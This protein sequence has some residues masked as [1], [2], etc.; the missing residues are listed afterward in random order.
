MYIYGIGIYNFVLFLDTVHF[1]DKEKGNKSKMFKFYIRYLS[2][3]DLI[4]I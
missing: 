2:R 4:P 3:V 1:L